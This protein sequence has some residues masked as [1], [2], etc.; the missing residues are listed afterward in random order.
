VL[1]AIIKCQLL[2]R[3]TDKT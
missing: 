2:I 3:Q 1:L